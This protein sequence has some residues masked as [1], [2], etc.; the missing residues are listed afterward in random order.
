MTREA[1]AFYVLLLI[2]DIT[3]SNVGEGKNET[4]ALVKVELSQFYLQ[5]LF[6]IWKNGH[7]SDII[8]VKNHCAGR[9]SNG[10]RFQKEIGK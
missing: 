1:T 8:F 7:T 5:T 9:N 4:V 3:S 6:I 2:F 10:N